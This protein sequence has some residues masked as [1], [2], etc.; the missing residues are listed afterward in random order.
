MGLVSKFIFFLLLSMSVAAIYVAIERWISFGKARKQS[1]ALAEAIDVPLATHDV[2]EALRL[3]D[4]IQYRFAFLGRLLR[5][6][7][8]ELIAR[9][10][11][12]GLAASQRA[13][14]RAAM[15]EGHDLKRGMAILATVGSTAPFVGLVGTIFGIINAFAGMAQTGSG[16]LAAVSAGI[17]EALVAT[18]VGIAVAIIGVW[19]FNWFNEIAE[20]ISADMSLSIQEFVD[21]GE[22]LILAI[23]EGEVSGF[24]EGIEVP[25]PPNHGE[26]PGGG[27]SA[28]S[29]A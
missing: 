3:I 10:D 9:P 21:W 17:A 20:G 4:D 18:A 24:A 2:G 11:R 14:E 25:P 12:Q 13:L 29:G 8:S 28:S 27:V 5:A 16:G 22:K 23:E 7:L 15:V 1:R 26:D 19:L 6:G